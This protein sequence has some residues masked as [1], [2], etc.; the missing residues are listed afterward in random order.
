MG[1][2]RWERRLAR[3]EELVDWVV[4]LRA[5]KR[6]GR[7]GVR[8]WQA[9]IEAARRRANDLQRERLARPPAPRP[10]T[11]AAT[12]AAAAVALPALGPVPLPGV[13]P[14]PLPPAPSVEFVQERGG[15][16][17]GI[18]TATGQMASSAAV[19]AALRSG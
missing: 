13:R 4:Q 8:K 10:A 11:S 1:M 14:P 3:L 9:L 2:R 5:E 19:L 15:M 6:A 17:I 18:D 12:L 7:P 16:S